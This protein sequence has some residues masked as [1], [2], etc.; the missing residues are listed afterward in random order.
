MSVNI[1]AIVPAANLAA[2]N[3]VLE[4]HGRGPTSL[5]IGASTNPAFTWGDTPTHY[6]MS[7]QG[8]PEALAQTFM[9][10]EEN[11]LPALALG[12]EWGVNGCISSGDAIAAI[13][14]ANF[15]FAV[16]NNGYSPEAQVAASLAAYS[17][18]LYKPVGPP[19]E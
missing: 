15:A 2:M 18:P 5:T 3:A 16:Y 9:R 1:I 12:Y 19:P 17:V 4:A 10:F 14:P 8:A 11:A 13:Q 7:D 6:Y